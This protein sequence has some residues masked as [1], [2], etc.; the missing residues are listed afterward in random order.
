MTVVVG[1]Q[2]PFWGGFQ[3][4]TSSRVDHGPDPGYAQ[5]T[6]RSTLELRSPDASDTTASGATYVSAVPEAPTLVMGV[7]GLLMLTWRRHRTWRAGPAGAAA[8]AM[9]AMDATHAQGLVIGG[10]ELP[11]SLSPAST[12]TTVTC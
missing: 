5:G 11:A 7:A 12:T 2:Y 4:Y 8:A 10:F 3:A 1:G 6:A 9:L